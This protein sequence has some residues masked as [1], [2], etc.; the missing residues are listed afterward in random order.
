MKTGNQSVD[1]VFDLLD[2]VEF[3]SLIDGSGYK[4]H[5]P[6]NSKKVNY[7]VNSLTL[8]VTSLQAG[9]V[10]VNIHAPNLP[11]VKVEGVSDTQF[12]DS[13]KLGDLANAVVQLLDCQWKETFHTDVDTAPNMLQDSDGTWYINIR[14]NYYSVI[15]DFKNI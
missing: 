6:L 11:P 13:V 10:N 9:V 15:N 7:V 5:K 8:S 2:V 4:Y 3:N 12:P 14:V 1:D